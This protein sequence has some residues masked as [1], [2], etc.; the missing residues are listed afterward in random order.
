MTNTDMP[1]LAAL[2]G[3][4][5]DLRI[6]AYHLTLE[7]LNALLQVQLTVALLSK[8]TDDVTRNTTITLYET[9]A[10]ATFANTRLEQ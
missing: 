8:L 2:H 7:D 1:E 10:V 3:K 5:A 4:Q 9:A 6:S